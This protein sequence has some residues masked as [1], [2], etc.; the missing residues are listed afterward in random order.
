[1]AAV[2]VTKEEVAPIWA[3]DAFMPT[4]IAGET[5]DYGDPVFISTA[6]GKAYASDASA[7]GTAAFAGYC[8]GNVGAGQAVS[9]L[10][11]G[12]MYGLDVA[13]LD[14][15]AAIYVADG[16]GSADA[17]GTTSVQTAVVWPMSDPDLTKVV[18]VKADVLASAF[19]ANA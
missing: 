2:T 16:G 7:A 14:Y 13:S 19:A 6:D 4:V 11:E 5:L 15:G 3:Q 8:L 12:F 18:Y 17:A 9:I 1:M 10:S